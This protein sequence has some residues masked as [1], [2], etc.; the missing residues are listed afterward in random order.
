MKGRFLEVIDRI[1]DI[2]IYYKIIPF[3]LSFIIFQTFLYVYFTYI[4]LGYV[5]EKSEWIHQLIAMAL[6]FGGTILWLY[7]FIEIIMNLKYKRLTHRKSLF[8]DRTKFKKTYSELVSFYKRAN[9]TAIDVNKLPI[10]KWYETN[11]LIYG[12]IND[13]LIYF[14]PEKNGIV[15]C[16]WGTPGD[17][18]TT[19]VVIPSSRQFGL[20]YDRANK[21]YIQMGSC[22]VLDCKG[23]I[24][25]ANKD[26]RR[27]KRF[28]MT[29]PQNSYHFDPLVNIRPM[30]DE[31]RCEALDNLAF[32][33]IPDEKGDNGIYFTD[34]AREFFTGIFLYC[35]HMDNNISF[36]DICDL[37]AQKSYTEWGAII[38]KSG[39]TPSMRYTNKYKDENPRNVGGGYNKLSKIA[40]TFVNPTLRILLNNDEHCISPADLE[41]CNDVYIQ[42]DPNKIELYKNIITMIFN[43]FMSAALYRNIG[44]TPPICYIIDEFGQLP[45][46]PVI[47]QSAALMRAYNCSIMLCCQ[48]LAMVDQH[49]G[50]EGRKILMDCAKCHCFLSLMEPDTRDWATRLIGKKKVLRRSDSE[51]RS[52]E[53]SSGISISEAEEDIMPQN[54]FGTLPDEHEVMIYY[55]GKYIRAT[56]TYYLE[57]KKL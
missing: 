7:I 16:V 52:N 47:E 50:T 40:R 54:Q 41:N 53:I 31:E 5:S 26:Y 2:I 46:M 19:T 30:N 29:N 45:K 49:Y 15:S 20:E 28:S 22:M 11:G 32:T 13:K 39:Y 1:S 34:V 56:T 51:H 38:E 23:D 12:K 35:L 37:V 25:E 18:K 42:V 57:K 48:S 43:E 55:K 4:N 6:F 3:T 14:K 9:I 21:Q 27:I 8:A 24:F 33:V 44:Q 10:A 36:V 17:G